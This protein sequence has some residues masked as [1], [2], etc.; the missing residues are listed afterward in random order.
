MT[1]DNTISSSTCI[2]LLLESTYSDF[3]NMCELILYMK[4]LRYCEQTL[5]KQSK[6][7]LNQGS[8]DHS[9]MLSV[10]NSHL[11]LFFFFLLNSGFPVNAITICEIADF[12]GGKHSHRI[13]YIQS[14]CDL[15]SHWG[16]ENLTGRDWRSCV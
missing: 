9:N 7:M 15:C 5:E 6:F 12:A 11:K 13:P 3:I 14:L 1:L 4:H 16:L 10:E 2:F 8:P